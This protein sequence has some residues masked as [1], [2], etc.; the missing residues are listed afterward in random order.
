[1]HDE[2]PHCQMRRVE[3]VGVSTPLI[4]PSFSSSG[5]PHVSGIYDQMKDK[6][7]GVCLVSALDIALR[8]IPSDVTDEV[9]LVLIDSGMYEARHAASQ[10]IDHSLLGTNGDWV[11][12]GYLEIAGRIDLGANVILVN[13]DGF[14]SVEQQIRQA[15]EDF[16]HAPHAASDFLVKPESP[17]QL[18][19]VARLA[20]HTD[21]L[22]QF[23]VVGVTAREAGDSLAQRCSSIVMLRDALD[24]AGL[25]LPIHVFGAITPLEVLTYSLCGADIFDGLSWL[26]LSFSE[27]GSAAIDEAAFHV[28]RS[29]L[30]DFE[31]RAREWLSNLRRLYRLQE[32]LRRYS[33]SKDL[34]GL[35][36]EFPSARK[37]ARIAELAGAVIVKEIGDW[38][39]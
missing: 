24:D 21:E 12:H 23:N 10:R 22:E 6:L 26:R 39:T 19:N 34:D 9:N 20:Q 37:A 8:R 1:M 36:Q 28:E 33:L 3:K 29:N 13:Y 32:S 18:V 35:A 25:N 7:Y 14:E 27:N 16:S 5:F 4:V 30:T 17:A 2:R 11:R 38:S 31:L 15:S